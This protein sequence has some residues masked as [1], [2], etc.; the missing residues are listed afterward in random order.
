MIF[1]AVMIEQHLKCFIFI[2]TASY[3]DNELAVNHFECQL[4]MLGTL[5]IQP[6]CVFVCVISWNADLS[7]PTREPGAD[8]ALLHPAGLQ[9][10]L[11]LSLSLSQCICPSLFIS[12]FLLNNNKFFNMLIISLT[13]LQL[14]HKT[15]YKSNNMHIFGFQF[16]LLTIAVIEY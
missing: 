14:L 12:P 1:F 8:A 15:C 5:V 10:H 11:S 13:V 7:Q 9:N 3:V 2:I 4:H 16:N 6:R